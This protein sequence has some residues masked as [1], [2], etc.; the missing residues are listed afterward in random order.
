L[1]TE[2]PV[3]AMIVVVVLPFTQFVVEHIDIVM[4]TILVE[5]LIELLVVD[6]V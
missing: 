4:N 1:P 2:R 5:Q 3:R 6:A